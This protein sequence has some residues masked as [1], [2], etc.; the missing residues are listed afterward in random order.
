MPTFRLYERITAIR[1]YTVEAHDPSEARTLMSQSIGQMSTPD[2]RTYESHG[3]VSI[4]EDRLDVQSQ[5]WRPYEIWDEDLGWACGG[6]GY[7]EGNCS[8]PR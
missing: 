6:C 3:I 2:E 5:S 8:C 4:T 7:F 1:I